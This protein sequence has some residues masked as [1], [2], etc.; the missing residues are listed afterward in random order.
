MNFGSVYFFLLLGSGLLSCVLGTLLSKDVCTYTRTGSFVPVSVSLCLVAWFILF[1]RMWMEDSGIGGR[2][3][4]FICIFSV[5]FL[6]ALHCPILVFLFT[7]MGVGAIEG[8][9]EPKSG[10]VLK[11]SYDEAEKAVAKHEYDKALELYR[12]EK[13][14]DPDDSQVRV[15]IGEV[16]VKTGQ[17]E[18]AIKEFRGLLGMDSPDEEDLTYAILRAA[19]IYAMDLRKKISARSLIETALR[20]DLSEES[21]N[22]LNSRLKTYL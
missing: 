11:K 19:E 7:R 16:L 12:N 22:M 18:E 13:E 3:G 5:T 14:R 20:R 1:T 17:R 15:R 6:A 2:A 21:R 8:M 10:I 4:A 9:I